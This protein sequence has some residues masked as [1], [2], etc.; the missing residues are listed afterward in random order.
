MS[1]SNIFVYIM[2]KPKLIS[3]RLSS[4]IRILLQTPRTTDHTTQ[5]LGNNV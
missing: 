4:N 2:Y 3:T 5:L 1:M